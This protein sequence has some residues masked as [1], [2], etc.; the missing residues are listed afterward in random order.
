MVVPCP[1][2]MVLYRSS[3]S[4]IVDAVISGLTPLKLNSELAH[5]DTKGLAQ[6]ESKA[7]SLP[8]LKAGKGR[9]IP[10]PTA[11]TYLMESL[12]LT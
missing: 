9:E 10:R 7:E 11:V 4:A 1:G 5:P 2:Y 6:I 8:R 12:H 3:A